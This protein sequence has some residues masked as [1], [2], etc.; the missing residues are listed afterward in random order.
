MN[1]EEKCP[2]TI[3]VRNGFLARDVA[4]PLQRGGLRPH[5]GILLS[6]RFSHR[7]S[8]LIDQ[9]VKKSNVI[10]FCFFYFYLGGNG[11]RKVRGG[12]G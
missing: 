1:K 8:R 10:C 6:S 7:G 3:S 12:S 11:G 2:I 4:P 9:N 5:R